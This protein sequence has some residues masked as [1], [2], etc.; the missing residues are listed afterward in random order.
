MTPYLFHSVVVGIGLSIL[1][2]VLYLWLKR[3]NSSKEKSQRMLSFC[4]SL[5]PTNPGKTHHSHLDVRYCSK[6]QDNE[7]KDS[8]IKHEMT[9]IEINGY[10]NDERAKVFNEHDNNAGKRKHNNTSHCHLCC[11]RFFVIWRFYFACC[12]PFFFFSLIQFLLGALHFQW[13]QWW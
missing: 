4:F 12:W 6:L 11:V 7:R 3:N 2:T 1:W 8:K 13:C 10:S 5:S 9:R